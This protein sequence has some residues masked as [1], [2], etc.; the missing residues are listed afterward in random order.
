LAPY[1]G[2][3]GAPTTLHESIFSTIP[4]SPAYVGKAVTFTRPTQRYGL[5]DTN[6]NGRNAIQGTFCFE[7]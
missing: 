2:P 4:G 3:T 1:T 5:N 6:L 7:A